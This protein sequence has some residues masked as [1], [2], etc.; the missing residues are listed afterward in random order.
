MEIR[1]QLKTVETKRTVI[2]TD[3]KNKYEG[4]MMEKLQELREDYDFEGRKFKEETELLYSSKVNNDCRI[5]RLTDLISSFHWEH[6]PLIIVLQEY[7][8]SDFINDD[9]CCCMHYEGSDD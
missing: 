1:S 9:C 8:V 6:R 4:V 5:P 7:P 3:Y 2:E